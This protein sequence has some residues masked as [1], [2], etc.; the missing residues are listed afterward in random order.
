VAVGVIKKYGDDRGGSLSALITFYGFLSVFPLLL[1]LVT[2]VGLVVG[3]NTHAEKQIVN[4][5]LSE[6]PVIGANLG[7]S[8]KALHRATP[9]AFVASFLGLLWGSLGATNNLQRA[10]E[11]MWGVPRHKEA[12]LLRRV[13]RSVM[14]LGTIGAAVV[15]SAVL[16]GIST[17]GGSKASASPATYWIYTLVGA[18]AIN[19]GAYLLALHILA[20]GGTRW[21]TLLPGTLIGGIGWTALETLGGVLV[22]HTLRHTTQLYGFFAT[23]LGLVFWLSLGSQL[24]V[25]AG[26]TNV[27]LARHL[28]PRHL[29]DPPPDPVEVAVATA[30]A[31]PSAT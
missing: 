19:L 29:D 8:I 31:E 2:V 30:E 23:V 6:F 5:A 9:L 4:S 12:D 3:V 22:S 20:P 10:S 21:R 26:E 17:I 1:L 13:L 25:Y 24:F 7:D 27:V 15:G 28:W 18:A 16:A 14:L 11:V